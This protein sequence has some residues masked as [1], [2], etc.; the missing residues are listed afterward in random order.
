MI[1]GYQWARMIFLIFNSFYHFTIWAFGLT[2]FGEAR[3]SLRLHVRN[4]KPVEETNITIGVLALFAV[5]IK[6][7]IDKKPTQPFLQPHVGVL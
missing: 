7:A 4:P 2:T 5:Y 3:T 6:H 1:V